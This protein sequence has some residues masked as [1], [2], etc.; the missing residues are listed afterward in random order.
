MKRVFE[1]DTPSHHA[2]TAEACSSSDRIVSLLIVCLFLISIAW[3]SSI[4]PQTENQSALQAGND[5]RWADQQ[6]SFDSPTLTE[7]FSTLMGNASGSAQAE[8]ERREE[9]AFNESVETA[10]LEVVPEFRGAATKMAAYE[11]TIVDLVTDE[12]LADPAYLGRDR[13][14]KV[15]L[16]YG[17]DLGKL[18]NTLWGHETDATLIAQSL[19]AGEFGNRIG[20]VVIIYKTEEGGEPGVKLALNAADEERFAE[21]G[22]REGY[23]RAEDWSAISLHSDDIAF[24]EDPDRALTPGRPKRE[25]DEG[26]EVVVLDREALRGELHRSTMLL[27]SSE[28]RISESIK[29]EQFQETEILADEFVRQSDAVISQVAQ[30]PVETE[31]EPAR[32]EYL[33]GVREFRD[34]GSF[35]WRGAV[36]LRADDF[37]SAET[38]LRSGERHINAAHRMLEMEQMD[39]VDLTLPPPNPFPSAL[40]LG[41]RYTY[42]DE[43]G[44]NDISV[45]ID[46]YEIKSG[47][48]IVENGTAQRINAGYGKKFLFVVLHVTHI[49]FRGNGTDTIRTPPPERFTLILDGEEYTHSTPDRY[50]RELG[51]PYA[52]VVLERKEM[53]EGFLIYA[54]PEE[55]D[56]S[57]G[58][59]Q[60]DLGE[61]GRPVWRLG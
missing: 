2:H 55:A 19:Y 32:Q 8:K 43:A 25:G 48:T 38:T 17:N 22:D 13:G 39:Q 11:I 45:I 30:L 21:S 56:P 50:V 59:I 15:T 49:G 4:Q 46:G 14:I 29:N 57:T 37:Q 33:R 27:T 28:T 16:I 9:A 31:L 61:E 24:Y 3:G 52:S 40:S 36:Y 53:Y 7:Q 34:A 12:D 10:F 26:E 5:S 54:I 47:Y 23:I 6:L 44:A 18:E 41:E 35:L 58:Y 42:R 51:H 20:T 1:R 60:L